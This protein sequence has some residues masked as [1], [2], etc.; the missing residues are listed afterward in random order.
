MS[1]VTRRVKAT[2]PPS[3]W[4]NRTYRLAGDTVE[5]IDSLALELGVNQ[6][7]LVSFL[8]EVATSQLENGTFK[9]PIVTHEVHSVDHHY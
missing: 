3:G 1:N 4:V 9:V 5:S 7:D 6:S 8:L 2:P